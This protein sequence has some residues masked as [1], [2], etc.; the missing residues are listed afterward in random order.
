M[1]HVGYKLIKIEDDS[2]VE[3]WGG[4]NGQ[5]SSPPQVLFLPD[6]IQ[7]FCPEI[8]VEYFGHKLINWY[9]EP[10]V[11]D[12]VPVVEEPVVEEPPPEMPIE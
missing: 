12:L 10:V 5:L 2:V 8:D 3:S 11:E 4:I 9:V 7:V 6:N 1:E